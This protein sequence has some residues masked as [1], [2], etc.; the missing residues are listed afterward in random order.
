MP[1][2]SQA[3]RD[4]E[5]AN[6]GDAGYH[7]YLDEHALEMAAKFTIKGDHEMANWI[8]TRSLGEALRGNDGD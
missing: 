5:R 8:L 6:Y 2:R 7:K 1:H 3:A 4:A